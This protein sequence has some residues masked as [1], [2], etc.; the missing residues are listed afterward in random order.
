ML[1]RQLAEALVPR[2]QHQRAVFGVE[3][4]VRVD[5]LR[6]AAGAQ[7]DRALR[8]MQQALT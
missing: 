4:R 2:V 1:N 5:Q 6:L 8:K 7:N 3:G